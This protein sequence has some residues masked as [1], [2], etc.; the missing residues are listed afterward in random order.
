MGSSVS[1]CFTTWAC[2]QI[3][4]SHRIRPEFSGCPQFLHCAVNV[5]LQD[6]TPCLVEALRPDR[7]LNS[8]ASKRQFPTHLIGLKD[9]N[10]YVYPRGKV[11]IVG[12]LRML[13]IPHQPRETEGLELKCL[14]NGAGSDCFDNYMGYENAEISIFRAG[15]D[16]GTGWTE[17]MTSCSYY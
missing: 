11:R 3:R 6:L 7:P 8:T 10:T 15:I 12:Y 1:T 13:F 14:S 9:F 2:G 17:S 4:D 16:A 5:Q